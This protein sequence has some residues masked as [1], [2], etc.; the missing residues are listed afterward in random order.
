[1]ADTGDLKSPAPGACGFESRHQHNKKSLGIVGI[2]GLFSC[3]KKR[4]GESHE[5]APAGRYG[6]FGDDIEEI[7]RTVLDK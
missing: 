2:S 4:R 6:A 5:R 1:M 7:G 3:G